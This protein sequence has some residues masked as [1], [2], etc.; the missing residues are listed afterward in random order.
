MRRLALRRWQ[1]ILLATVALLLALLYTLFEIS[2]AKCWQLIGT[3]VCQ[4]AT[5]E[6]LVALSFDDGPTKAG[7][8]AV[9]PILAA[10]DARAT[11]F[12]IGNDLAKSP[13]QGRRL[14]EAGHELGNHSYT[15]GRMWGLF[16]GGYEAEIRRT[17]ALLRAE[18]AAP[19]FFRPPYGKRLTGLPIAVDRTGYRTIMWTFEDP[20]R[21][22]DPQRYAETILSEIRPG[23]VVIMHIMYSGNRTARDALPLILAGLKARGYRAVTVGELLKRE[24]R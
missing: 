16:P 11:F 1:W 7:V 23:A 9:L 10:H 18:G 14:L 19:A 8:D 24:G 20:M 4:V 12:L 6:K 21:E 15:H 22:T 2:R 17:D 5:Q 13:G 3:P